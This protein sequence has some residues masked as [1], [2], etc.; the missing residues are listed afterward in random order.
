MNYSL[1]FAAAFLVLGVGAFLLSR[2]W[3]HLFPS[4]QRLAPDPG[5][6]LRKRGCARVLPD[7]G[8]M[9]FEMLPKDLPLMKPLHLEVSL[10]G[11]EVDDIQVDIKGLNM[12]MG[13]NR[14]RLD[15]VSPLVWQGSTLLPVC[16]MQ[17]MEWSASVWLEIDGELLAIPHNFK[18]QRK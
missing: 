13:L 1:K 16:S 5:C 11:I 4:L 10:D 15:Q 9:R 3:P 7:G 2:E 14:V 8:S 17:V 12:D 6:D 18:T